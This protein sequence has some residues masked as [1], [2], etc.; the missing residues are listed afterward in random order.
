MDTG[1]IDQHVVKREQA[2]A[3]GGHEQMVPPREEHWQ[4]AQA[5]PCHQDQGRQRKAIGNS[6][7][8]GDGKLKLDRDPGRSPDQN[9][10]RI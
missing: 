7:L 9:N 4:A 6:G 10:N 8:G 5:T 3:K 2:D 1:D